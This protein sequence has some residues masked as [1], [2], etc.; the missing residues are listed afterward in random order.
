MRINRLPAENL[1]SSLKA[2]CGRCKAE[3]PVDNAPV[4]V[5]DSTFATYAE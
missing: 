2:R 5:T 1:A 4:N 3:L